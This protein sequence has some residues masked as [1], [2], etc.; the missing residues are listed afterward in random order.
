VQGSRPS[1][2]WEKSEILG[3]KF[4]CRAS[5]I[6]RISIAENK[7]NRAFGTF[8]VKT[9]Q[10]CTAP[11]DRERLWTSR[12]FIGRNSL[13]LNIAPRLPI[14]QMLEFVKEASE[15]ETSLSENP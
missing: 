12:H 6:L 15:D 4:R 8:M 1:E 13:V 14:A 7:E 3:Y 2:I 11:M 10:G 9:I 5:Y